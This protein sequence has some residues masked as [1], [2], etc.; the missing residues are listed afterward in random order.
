MDVFNPGILGLAVIAVP[1]RLDFE[2]FGQPLF[3]AEV[4]VVSENGI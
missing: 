4:G 2:K 3:P 1:E